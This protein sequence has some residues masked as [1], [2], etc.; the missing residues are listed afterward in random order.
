MPLKIDGAVVGGVGREVLLS[1][2]GGMPFS[3][4]VPLYR[5]LYLKF[6]KNKLRDGVILS[7]IKFSFT[8]TCSII[9]TTVA[10]EN[11][12]ET[13]VTLKVVSLLSVS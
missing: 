7:Q 11:F 5:G 6:S 4:F 10:R 2:V 8:S 12:G 1:T 9:L 3:P 13:I